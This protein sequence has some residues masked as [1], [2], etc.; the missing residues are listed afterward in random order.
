[1]DLS[2]IKQPLCTCVL[3][4]LG[5]TGMAQAADCLTPVA[6]LTEIRVATPGDPASG[7]VLDDLDWFV[8]DWIGEVFGLTVN[9][10]VFDQKADQ[11]PGLVRLY[12]DEGLV[13]YEL[14]TFLSVDGEMAYRNRLFDPEL[15][16]SQGP[17]GDMQ[18]RMAVGKEGG[19][20]FFDRITFAPNGDDCAVVSFLLPNDAGGLDKH[21]VFFTRR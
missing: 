7:V 5:S 11:L 12:N 13:L 16:V 4:V 19:I 15:N 8:G 2:G 20:V 14:S 10:V 21:S 6:N 1:M 3:L 17:T 9:H 18:T